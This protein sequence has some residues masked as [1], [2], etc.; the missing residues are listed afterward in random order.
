MHSKKRHSITS[1][2]IGLGLGLAVLGAPAL[3]IAQTF[4]DKPMR[5]ISNL[6]AGGPVDVYSRILCEGI[7]LALGQP[8]ITE[9]RP[10]GSGYIAL[11]AI[12]ASAPD[13]HTIGAGSG[14]QLVTGPLLRPAP[15]D[16]VNGFTHMGVIWE[17]P[18]VLAATTASKITSVPQLLAHARANPGKLNYGSAGIGTSQHLGME[19][20][21]QREGG[22]N[23]VHIPYTRDVD[24]IQAFR[25]NE[26]QVTVTG[27][28]VVRPML[29]QGTVTILATLTRNRNPQMPDVP[30]AAEAG[31]PG[32][33]IVAWGSVLGPP[34]VPRE[35]VQR[36]NRAFTSHAAK[37]EVLA[38]LAVLFTPTFTS[39]E[40]NVALMTRE[41]ATW[42]SVIE[43]AQIKV[44]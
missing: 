31:M 42:K 38:K 3:G 4:P 35:I 5:F 34:G 2:I 17:S 41:I 19:W 1:R 13:G 23:I 37:P 36:I 9:N 15:Y 7:A 33:V 27:L 25:T 16:P 6:A 12:A 8:V 11:Q 21:K 43:R 10:G 26:Y 39:P 24:A 44:D 40:E 29:Q 30:T 20:L 18:F 14:G 22:V 28:A 32:Y